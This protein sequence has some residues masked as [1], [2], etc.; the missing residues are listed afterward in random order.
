LCGAHPGAFG[1]S[2]WRGTFGCA[3][4]HRR[5]DIAYITN[6]LGSALKGDPRARVLAA[7]ATR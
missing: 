3:D 1:K 4:P 6:R 5:R 2:G 7:L